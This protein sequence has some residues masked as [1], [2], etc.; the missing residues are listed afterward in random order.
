[1][2]MSPGRSRS[3][4]GR[5]ESKPTNCLSGGTSICSAYC[6]LSAL[7]ERVSRSAKKSAMAWSFTGPPEALKASTAAP[8]P[9]PPQP[10]NA[11]RIVLSSAACTR[12]MAT[13][14]SAAPAATVPLHCRNSRRED[15]CACDN[16]FSRFMAFSS[17]LDQ[18]IHS[19][20]TKLNVGRRSGLFLRVAA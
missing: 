3:I 16:G 13:P 7:C 5:N 4:A 8:L 18:V 17:G 11:R 2:A 12:G 20:R 19:L 15:F 10:I 14:A 9:R 1:M 6:S